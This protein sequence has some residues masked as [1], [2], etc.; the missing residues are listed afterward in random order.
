LTIRD[1]AID[2]AAVWRIT[3]D[4]EV[5]QR[6]W[7][8]SGVVYHAGTGDTHQ[9]DLLTV[10]VLELLRESPATLK[11]LARR[12]A[13]DQDIDDNPDLIE[14]LAHVLRELCRLRIVETN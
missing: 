13:R 12:L 14:R 8:D 3:E 4:Y 6:V 11:A 2:T 7:E 1:H 10:A 5:L 9:V